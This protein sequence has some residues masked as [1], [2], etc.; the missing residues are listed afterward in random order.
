MRLGVNIDHIATIRNARG[1][2]NPDP[3]RA[4]DII[5]QAGAHG[6]T[7]HLREDRRHIRDDDVYKIKQKSQLPVN[8]EIAAT[9]QMVDIACDVKPNACCIVPEK[10]EEITTEGGLDVAANID[11]LTKIT[12]K[13]Q[14]NGIKVSLFIDTEEKQIIAASNVGADIVEFHTGKYSNNYHNLQIRDKLLLN[15][16]E[17]VKLATS[18]N[19]ESH[20]GH[21]LD[22]DNVSHIAEIE[23]IAEL[24]IGH[25]LIGEAIFNGL[26]NSV[27]HMLNL[28]NR[29][30]S[31][32][33]LC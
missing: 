27:K 10:R 2:V 12:R 5:H 7:I 1:E 32:H 30:S 25:F 28:I 14:S 26:G 23:N 33:A 31:G 19:I 21:G 24:N 4:L 6:V 3:V 29:A 15:L 13:L 17:S 18:L 9:S 11:N 22:F 16:T 20:A 8:L